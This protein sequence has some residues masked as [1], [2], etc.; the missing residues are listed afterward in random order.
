MLKL[1]SKGAKVI[2]L[3]HRLIEIGFEPGPIDGIFGRQTLRAVKQFQLQRGFLLDGVVGPQTWNA[4]WGGNSCIENNSNQDLDNYLWERFMGFVNIQ[5]HVVYGPGRGWFDGKK[6]IVTIGPGGLGKTNWSIKPPVKIGP[7][8]HCSSLVNLLLGYLLNTNKQWTHSGNRPLLEEL[9]LSDESLHP[10]PRGGGAKWRGYG[11][12]IRRL[13]SDGDSAV[14]QK[15]RFHNPSRFLDAEEIWDRRDELT[16]INVFS[17]SDKKNGRWQRDHHVG[18][19]AYQKGDDCV[20]RLAADGWRRKKT[21]RYY[22]GD[23]VSFKKLSPSWFKKQ[24]NRVYQIFRLTPPLSLL[25]DAAKQNAYPIVV[26]K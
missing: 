24:T 2:E 19:F 14:R 17:L 5:K 12:H 13:A 25:A 15:I 7:S 1:R 6:W 20:Y 18:V 3:Q 26:E 10:Q 22:S 8:L 11:T 9:L 23:P 16:S 4:L 21:P